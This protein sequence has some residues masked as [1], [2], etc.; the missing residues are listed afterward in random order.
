MDSGVKEY[1]R[2]KIPICERF[3]KKEQVVFWYS[4]CCKAQALNDAFQ[5][6][7]EEDVRQDNTW[8]FLQI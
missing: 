8:Y 7:K 6:A 2:D 1:I 3:A 4:T 5:G